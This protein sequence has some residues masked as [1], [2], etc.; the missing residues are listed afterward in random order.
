MKQRVLPLEGIH[1]FRDYGSYASS[2]GGKVKPG[3][4]WRSAQHSQASESDLTQVDA[5]ELATV[6]DLRGD[7]EREANPCRR[8][9]GFTAQV[10]VNSG[11]TAGL[12]PHLEAAAAALD[13]QSAKRALLGYYR[14][15]PHRENLL[16]MIRCYFLALARG[17]G[18]SLVHCV[19]GKDRTGF[20]VAM[21]H[22]VLGVHRDDILA[23][24]ELTNQAGNIEARIADGAAHIRARYGA[25]DDATVRVLMGVDPEFLAASFAAIDEGHGDID[26]YLDEV[27]GVDQAMREKLRAHYL[28]V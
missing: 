18:P 7:S 9:P 3:L 6:I 16:P 12:A 13:A 17:E 25:I 4:L 19:A 11:E 26:S 10:F 1:N 15:M 20:A 28:E 5:L 8:G 2:F 24:Y 14:H 21:L 22:H 27:L 23:D